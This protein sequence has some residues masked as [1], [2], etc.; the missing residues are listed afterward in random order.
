MSF[1]PWRRRA[2]IVGSVAVCWRWRPWLRVGLDA[3]AA[4]L[5]G[6]DRQTLP[7]W[8]HRFNAEG[9]AGLLDRKLGGRPSKLTA[10]QK[11]ELAVIVEVGPDRE[12]TG[13]VRWRR[14]DL[15]AVIEEAL[16]GG[17]QRALGLAAAP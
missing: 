9:A 6:V 17:L 4:A 14:V 12:E 16:R 1:A 5:G 11:V 8:V 2:G 7:D 13:L 3:E 15:K 10:G